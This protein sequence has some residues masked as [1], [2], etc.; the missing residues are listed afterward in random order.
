MKKLLILI[1]ILAN[2]L[3]A[4]AQYNTD[5]L[6][7]A[8]RS[9]LYYEDY[10]V[11]IQYFN[12][13][14]LLKPHLYEP[15]YLRGVAKYYL[16]DFVG[17]EADC[18]EAIDRNPFVN[19]V[20][21]L[22]ALCRIQQKEYESA[23]SDYTRALRDA[24]LN[25]QVWYNRTICRI[26]MK[27]YE[28]AH[29]DIDTIMVRWK[30]YA[31]AYSLKA[32]VYLLEKDTVNAAKLL[33][34]SLQ[35]DAY[36]GEAWATMAM[37]SIAK[38][39]Y[40]DGDEQLSKAIHLKPKNVGYYI[41]RALARYN[42]NNLR[43]AMTDYDAAIDLDPNN[44]L[45]HYNR[46]LLRQQVGDDN[47]AIEDFNFVVRMEPDNVLA[48]FNR[49]TLLDKTGNLRAAIKDYT[50]VI[51]QYPNFWTGLQMRASCYRRLG[52]TKRAEQDEF[53]VLKSQLEKRYGINQKARRSTRKKSENDLEKYRDLVV[54]DEQESQ[55]EYQN[56]YRG[57]V[58]NRS[59]VVD[60]QPMYCLSDRRYNNGVRN[61]EPYDAHA[62][63]MN[64]HVTCTRNYEE[65]ANALER[66]ELQGDTT[67]L[68]FWQRAIC[69]DM[70]NELSA[71]GA[72]EA[73]LK[74]MN[75]LGDLQKAID[76]AP[77]NPYLLYCRAN[78]RVR[79]KEYAK[80]IDDYSKAIEMDANLAEA[81]YNRGLAYIYNNDKQQ[82]ILDLSKAGELGLYNA[83]SI[84]KK[85]KNTK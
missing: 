71:Q 63:Q 49:A 33:D 45:A 57:R 69:N 41:N 53:R 44:Y 51:E 24:P 42:I 70:E 2:C 36:D 27:D 18:T 72:M 37:I 11:S 39:E 74:Q 52:D 26:E 56:E 83:Y 58:Q 5:R 65:A 12:Q 23:I 8:G 75:V 84:I 48:L 34:Q 61:N 3:G 19:N 43:G 1:T 76:M 68:Y 47:R 79:R 35:I 13:A 29:H 30:N 17:A 22:R 15:W 78:I 59:V 20:Y 46:G 38:Q 31:K 66:L 6:I 50:K 32:E 4:V 85:Y 55:H 60:L 28:A 82:G 10:V 77:D 62:E 14:L 80:A 16:G 25:L 40:K 21:E 73:D 7:M 9:A 64:L 81:Y 67:A 54:A